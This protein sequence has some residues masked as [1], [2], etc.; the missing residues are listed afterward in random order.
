MW[1]ELADVDVPVFAMEIAHDEAPVLGIALRRQA[2]AEVAQCKA[3][4]VK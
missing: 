3:E 1:V 2:Q 4:V